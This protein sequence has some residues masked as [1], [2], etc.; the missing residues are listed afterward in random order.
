MK[1]FTCLV[2]LAL[3]AT[4]TS[5]PAAFEALTVSNLDVSE[6]S[7]PVEAADPSLEG[8]YWEVQVHP[9]EEPQRF[10]GSIEE[11]YHEVL[12]LNPNYVADFAM[13]ATLEEPKIQKRAR[14]GPPVCHLN[15]YANTIPFQEGYVYL[16][17]MNAYLHIQPRLCGRVSCSHSAGIGICN[18]RHDVT[19]A[20]HSSLI[21]EYTGVDI[22]NSCSAY[23]GTIMGGQQFDDG[24]WNVI[25]V[26]M[27][28]GAPTNWGV[29]SWPP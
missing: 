25:A 11:V 12:E 10:T 26:R 19:W 9:D 15:N 20:I 22:A 27:N 6:L 4:V 18:D 3:V 2:P 24:G 5:M 29:G 14:S 8:T 7:F 28:C 23:R 17:R 16:R 21:A 1:H 13:N